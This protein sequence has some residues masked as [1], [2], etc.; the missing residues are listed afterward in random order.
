[1][2]KAFMTRSEVQSR[3]TIIRNE[4][5]NR[6]KTGMTKLAKEDGK[7]PSTEELQTEMYALT[8]KL[9]RME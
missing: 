7:P 5:E 6:H 3:I 1:M 9:S 2:I 4:L 8:Y